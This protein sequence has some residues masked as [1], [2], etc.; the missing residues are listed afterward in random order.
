M[1]FEFIRAEKAYFPV[2]VL[3]KVMQVSRSGYYAWASRRESA[4]SRKDRQL[5]ALIRASYEGSRKTYGSPRVHADLAAQGHRVSRKRIIKLMRAMGLRARVRRRY[6]PQVATENEQPLPGN[7][8]DRNFHADAP[9]KVWVADTTELRTKSGRL[10]LA[11]VLDLY[12]RVIVGWAISAVNDR[13]LVLRALDAAL[14]H[15]GPCA[16]LLH[17][18]DQGS[19][20]ASDDYQRLLKQRGI[21]S[22][23]SR[24]GNCYD[25][26]CIESFHSILKKE[27][28]Y[29]EKFK[30][31]KEAQ[32][33]IF[34]YIEFF[35]NR[36]RVHSAIGYL[37]PIQCE[38][39][40]DCVA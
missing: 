34:E 16:G 14:H 37:T 7:V 40:Y 18:S 38:Q 13:H 28:V 30:T 24:K 1:R 2:K 8:L 19:P 15:R 20:Y 3:C 22:S 35:Y 5:V 26:A 12:A 6:R 32:S 10:F 25:N 27:L 21:R 31:R 39:M 29:L 4:R 9:N 33:K 36:K 23:M 17:H 11:A